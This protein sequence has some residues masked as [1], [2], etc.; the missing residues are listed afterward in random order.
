MAAAAPMVFV[1]DDDVSV[2]KSLVR[3]IKTAGYEAEPF[4]L[5]GGLPGASAL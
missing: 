4:H 1:V 5:G 3:L 2:R